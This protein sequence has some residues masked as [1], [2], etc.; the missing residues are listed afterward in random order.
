MKEKE[1]VGIRNYALYY[2]SGVQESLGKVEDAIDGYQRI[3]DQ[4]GVDSLRMLQSQAVTKL[5]QL[6]A[7]QGK[8][9]IADDRSERWESQ[10]RPDERQ[11]AEVIALKMERY[12]ARI[13]WIKDLEKKDKDDRNAS[14]LTRDTREQLRALMRISGSHQDEVRK[15]LA[16]LGAEPVAA[17]ST[18]VPKVKNFTE[19]LEAATERVQ[20]GE[21]SLLEIAGLQ[22]KVAEQA[23]TEQDKKAKEQQIADAK[24]SA[25]VNFDQATQLL[26]S[27]LRLFSKK[28]DRAQLFEARQKLGARIFQNRSQPI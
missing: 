13:A 27:S 19:A 6:F 16:N 15:L 23:T 5:V 28:D 26:Q 14:K 7:A 9:Q 17:K 24:E 10:V 3:A 18:D 21:A 25:R 20:R 11:A 2:R 22:E 4:E 12:R 1:I 8:F